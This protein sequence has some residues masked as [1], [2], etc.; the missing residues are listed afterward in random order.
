MRAA[1][2]TGLDELLVHVRNC[3]RCIDAPD[4]APLPHAPRPVVRASATARIGICGQAPGTRVHA[5]G[6][7]FTDASGDRLRAWMGVSTDDFYDETRIAIVPMG[8][9]FPG[10]DAKGHDLP[11]RRECAP[12]W[13]AR[14]FSLLPDLKLLL[15]VGAYAQHWHLAGEP[16]SMTLTVKDWRRHSGKS[17]RCPAFPLPHPSW[18]NT[19]WIAKNPWFADDLLP[20]LRQNIREILKE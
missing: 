11:P 5:S 17:G 9:C 18:R 6:L 13:R 3:R 8:F 10:L 2:L 15:L 14:I 20:A 4:G 1:P 7:P 19:G 16:S 12:L